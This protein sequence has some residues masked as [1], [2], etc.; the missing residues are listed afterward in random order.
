MKAFVMDVSKCSGCYSCQL[1]CKDEFCGN[2]WTPYAKPQPETGQFWGKMTEYVLGQVPH[3]K[4]SFIFTPCQHCADAPCVKACPPDIAA[5]YTRPDGLVII[6]PKKCT[7][8][9]KCLDVCPYDAIYFNP[10]FGIAQKCTGCA[11]LVDRKVVFA[12]R[13]ADSCPHEALKFGEEAD[14]VDYAKGEVLHP[15][16]GLKT[17]MRYLGLPKR[18]IAG[19]VYDPAAE[20]VVIGAT[21]TVSG[22]GTATAT[23]NNFGDFWIDG[24]K[25]GTFAVKIEKGGKSKTISGVKTDKDVSLGD[26]PLA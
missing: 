4:M 23:T 15:E 24:L 2:D 17:R 16:Y 7:G 19:T 20:E 25:V 21:V 10:Q 6:D 18:L 3:V 11:H 5:L 12:P 1:A 13:C 9:R 8:C 22:D 26:I 14:L